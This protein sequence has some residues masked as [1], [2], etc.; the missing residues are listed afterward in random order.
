MNQCFLKIKTFDT[1]R[2]AQILAMLRLKACCLE[3]HADLLEKYSA[4][5]TVAC[6]SFFLSFSDIVD[7]VLVYHI[8]LLPKLGPIF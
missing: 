8:A 1:N 3:K 6:T 4:Y 2:K 5:K 7:I